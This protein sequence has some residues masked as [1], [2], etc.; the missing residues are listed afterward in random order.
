VVVQERP[1]IDEVALCCCEFALALFATL[2]EFS[3]VIAAV[4]EFV[5]SFAVGKVFEPLAM[6]V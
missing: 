3:L 6:V 5:Q 2:D 1:L 4:G